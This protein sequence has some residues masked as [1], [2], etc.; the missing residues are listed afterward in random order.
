MQGNT[1]LTLSPPQLATLKR[2]DPELASFI[3]VVQV[4]VAGFQFRMVFC[5][6]RPGLIKRAFSYTLERFCR[7]NL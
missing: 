6:Q 5:I 4:S 7:V 1:S 2:P 3:G